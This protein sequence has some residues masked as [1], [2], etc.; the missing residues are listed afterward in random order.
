MIKLYLFIPAVVVLA[1]L[2]S[3]CTKKACSG[4]IRNIKMIGF[5]INDLDSVVVETFQKNTTLRVDSI[6]TH[7][8]FGDSTYCEL[9]LLQDIDPNQDYKITVITT[10]QIY[11]LTNINTQQQSCNTC[12][13]YH[14]AND[15]Y[16]SLKSYTVNGQMQSNS[17][18][19]IT[20]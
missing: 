5:N 8:Y 11:L 4:N 12:F 18:V 7:G 15:Y 17:V 2:H 20:N 19:E 14:P 1:G 3:C 9:P 10:Q 13:P 16:T 6:L